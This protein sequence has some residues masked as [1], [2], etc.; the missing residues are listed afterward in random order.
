MCPTVTRRVGEFPRQCNPNESMNL[1]GKAAGREFT[2]LPHSA[3]FSTGYCFGHL[4]A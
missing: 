2:I 3:F 1:P 4:F